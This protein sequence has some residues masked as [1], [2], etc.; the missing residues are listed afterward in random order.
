MTHHNNRREFI[1]LSASAGGSLL[2]LPSCE[3]VRR[4][5]KAN[6]KLNI[7]IVGA[8]GKGRRDA[9]GVA[10]ENIVALCDVDD[11]RADSSYKKYPDARRYKDYRVMLEKEK[12][13]AVVISTPDH[14]HAPVAVMAMD[15]GLH[16]YCQKPLTHTVQEARLL[17]EMARKTGVTTSMGNQGTGT[18]GF[19]AGVE[20]V[21]A[22]AIGKVREVHVWTNRPIWPQGMAP[23]PKVDP[24][25]KNLHWDLWL[26][27]APFR[28][29]RKG[30]APFAWRGYWDFGTGALGDMACHLMNLPYM[31]LQLGMPTSVEAEH[32][33]C[34]NDSAPKGSKIVYEFPA[35]GDLPPVKLTWYDGKMNGKANKPPIDLVPGKKSL[36]RGGS[37]MVGEKGTILS[38]D[39]YG[40]FQEY[41]PK[42]Q[43]ADFKPA[44]V[45]LQRGPGTDQEQKIYVEWIAACKGFGP[46]PLA[47]FDYAGPLTEVVLLGNV[48]I[49]TGEK[50]NWNS[51][52]LEALNCAKAENYIKKSYREGFGVGLG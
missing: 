9:K 40:Q 14:A 20:A 6:E 17:T 16:I 42:G 41:F 39:D 26:N 28:P 11:R 21:R 29:Y 51:D 44:E 37:I 2:F 5:F 52:K 33:G 38:V 34:N 3:S 23:N 50:I 45:S 30:Y 49:R 24:I 48:S 35:R 31:A 22:G 15:L 18:D 36:G 7:G 27:S 1:K 10:S 19:R 12:L 8:G 4:T 25:P 46:A 43:F 13:D 47:N 32:S